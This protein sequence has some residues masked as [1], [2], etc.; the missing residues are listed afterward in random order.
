MVYSAHAK[1]FLLLGDLCTDSTEDGTL[2][3]VSL[4]QNVP[5]DQKFIQLNTDD[6]QAQ[7]IQVT[8]QTQYIQV[9]I[10]VSMLAIEFVNF[11]S[12]GCKKFDSLYLS[13]Q[14][15]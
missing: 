7:M 6:G 14:F 13:N 4:S 1:C 3:D 8:G 10:S 5:D 2:R 12:S 11:V 15:E 9:F